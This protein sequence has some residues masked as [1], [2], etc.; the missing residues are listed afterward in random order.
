M[1]GS[2]P[3]EAISV[4]NSALEMSNRGDFS[5]A[6]NE[7][8]KAIAIFPKFLE[9]YNNI[10]EIYSKMGRRETGRIS[11][12]LQALTIERNYR[13]LLNLG[14]EYYNKGQN[15][16]ALSHFKEAIAL[17]DDF[18]EGHFYAGMAYFN[19]KDFP[20]AEK[21]F[22]QVLSFDRN[23]E[24]AN[25]LL[26]YIYYEWKQYE[27][28]LECLDRIK[29]STQDRCFISKYYG[30]CHYYLGHFELAVGYLTEAMSQSP[31]YGKFRDYLASLTYEN[32]L[33]EIGDVDA[34]IR[35]LEAKMASDVPS[36][37]EYTHL[38]MLYIF[39]GEYR[40]AED[41]LLSYRMQ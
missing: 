2:V 7:Y 11:T 41:I 22:S 29:D 3:A 14:V 8:G 13:V 35:E 16:P 19:I 1:K 9:A 5:T 30:F 15:L 39:K 10:G 12:Y 23:H 17:K 40:K 38:S 6:L 32:K 31:Q 18:V 20:N 34:C 21:H 36:I 27:R 25:Y 37:G 28:V 33:K 4:Y 24:K 26:S